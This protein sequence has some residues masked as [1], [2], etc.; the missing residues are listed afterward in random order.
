MLGDALGLGVG[1]GERVS[2]A[3]RCAGHDRRIRR[4][5]VPELQA[6]GA[7]GRA[8]AQAL[9]GPRTTR[10][11][12]LSTRRG[13]LACADRGRGCGSGRRAGTVLG[14]ARPSVRASASFS[15]CAAARVRAEA[16]TSTCIDLPRS[17]RTTYMYAA[18]AMTWTAAAVTVCAP[19]P[20][21][22]SMATSV[23]SPSDS[24]QLAV[25]R[26]RK[27]ARRS[28]PVGLR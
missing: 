11:P 28:S 21:F 22:T 4:F 12:P 9:R 18:S 26:Y 15:A 17:L 10:I 7:R 8:A 19:L 6:G 5:R 27:P 14:D 24:S 25:P 20:R 16:S 23:T 3:E 1:A 2:G 13:P